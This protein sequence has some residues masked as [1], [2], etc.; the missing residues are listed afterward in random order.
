MQVLPE[1]LIDSINQ[2]ARATQ[3]AIGKGSARCCAEI[4]LPEF[5]DPIS[6]AVFSE[7]GDQMRWWK[8]C[9]RFAD[10]LVEQSGS[11]KV[12][13]VRSDMRRYSSC[14]SVGTV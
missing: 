8:L 12:T 6:G 2:A 14:N 11:S 3:E 7:E 1:S 5:W 9:K 10:D 13:V 4:L